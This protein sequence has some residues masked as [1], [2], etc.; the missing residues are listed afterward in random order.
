M[1]PAEGRAT[2]AEGGH[3][4]GIRR[5]PYRRRLRTRIILAF[6]LLGFGLTLLLAFATTWTRTKFENDLVEEMLNTNID[7][8]AAQYAFGSDAQMPAAWK[9]PG[10]ISAE[11][12]ARSAPSSNSVS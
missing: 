4:A 2:G 12:K 1:P 7:Q 5:R 3:D 10:P 6:V 9:T 11:I 8:Y